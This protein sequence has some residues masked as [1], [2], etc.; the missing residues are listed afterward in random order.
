MDPLFYPQHHFIVS[1]ELLRSLA[2][3]L[4][5]YCRCMLLYGITKRKPLFIWIYVN[6]EWI[7]IA[8]FVILVLITFVAGVFF[9]SATADFV[10]RYP[11]LFGPE[12]NQAEVQEAIITHPTS[13]VVVFTLVALAV[14]AEF[15]YFNLVLLNHYWN[16]KEELVRGT[17][18]GYNGESAEVAFEPLNEE[19]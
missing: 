11:E 9:A 7:V 14:L 3:S 10:I 8:I 2:Q 17:G 6:W 12:V 5:F 1:N 15:A 18:V 13:A 16:L 4:F 19:V